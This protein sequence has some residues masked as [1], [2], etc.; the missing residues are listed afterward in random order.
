MRFVKCWDTMCEET[1]PRYHAIVMVANLITMISRGNILDSS[2][3]CY[4]Y[5]QGVKK[6]AV[7]K[8]TKKNSIDTCIADFLVE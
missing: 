6:N 8:Q 2:L 5:P 3:T 7:S 1:V 4:R